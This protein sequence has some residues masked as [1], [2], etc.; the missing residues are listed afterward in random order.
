MPLHIGSMD[1]GIDTL[2]K[3]VRQPYFFQT[4]DKSYIGLNALA[5]YDRNKSGEGYANPAPVLFNIF[6]TKF[7]LGTEK[8]KGWSFSFQRSNGNIQFFGITEL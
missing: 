3:I 4:L 2:F 7:S 1:G 6:F 5:A 8:N